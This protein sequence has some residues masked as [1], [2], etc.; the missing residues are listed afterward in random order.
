MTYLVSQ[1]VNVLTKLDEIMVNSYDFSMYHD[2]NCK[3]VYCLE[4][5]R[6]LILLL[7]QIV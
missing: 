4:L 7:L 5:I 2:L 6:L 3:L 1:P